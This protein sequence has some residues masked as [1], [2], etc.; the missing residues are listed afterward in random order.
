MCAGG[1]GHVLPTGLAPQRP[2]TALQTV[3]FGVRSWDPHFPSTSFSHPHLDP[4]PWSLAIFARCP[5]GVGA[6]SRQLLRRGLWRWMKQLLLAC[7]LWL[8]VGGAGQEG[9]PAGSP[10]LEHLFFLFLVF[11]LRRGQSEIVLTTSSQSSHVP[12]EPEGARCLGS[13]KAEP[14]PS[15]Y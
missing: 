3:W 8:G 1:T 13:L 15:P 7:P 11:L 4:T 2:S 14:G 12:G 5:V 9:R 6:E 10:L